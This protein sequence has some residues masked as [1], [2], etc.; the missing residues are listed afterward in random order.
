MK[1]QMNHQEI[2]T[3]NL[4]K[5]TSNPVTL[6]PKTSFVVLAIMRRI[7]HNAIDNGDVEVHP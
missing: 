3:D 1:K 5:L 2:G 4:Q 7:N 6:L